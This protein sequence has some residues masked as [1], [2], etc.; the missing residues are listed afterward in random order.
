MLSIGLTG[1]IG[2][3]KSTVSALFAR[4]G[5]PVLDTDL[6]ARQLVEPGQPALEE[7]HTR[8]GPQVLT[9][10]GRLDR[11]ALR[12]RVFADPE[13]RGA[14]EGILH[15]RIRA[16][17]REAREGL[18]APYC[19]VVIPLL[20]ESGQRELVD[21]ILVVDVPEAEQVRRTRAR[22]GLSEATVRAIM[23]AQVPRAVRLEGADEVIS[24]DGDEAALEAR[25]HELHRRY[26]RLAAS[27]A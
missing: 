7:I 22:D 27:E 9:P 6:I 20:F 25:V 19:V 10:D 3:G 4:L 13:Q 26:L 8:F 14:L 21:R 1:G 24:N 18:S 11:A 15:P 2:S 17:V 12:E 16:A 5:V 23:A